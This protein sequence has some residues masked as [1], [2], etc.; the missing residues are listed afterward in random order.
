MTH[1]NFQSSNKIQRKRNMKPPWKRCQLLL[2]MSHILA[3][4]PTDKL[5]QRHFAASQRISP[6]INNNET[7]FDNSMYDSNKN[8]LS[9][10][11]NDK[12][13]L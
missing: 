10:Q 5:I 2:E 11:D 7:P 9:S 13:K 1:Q 12:T 8:D 3:S 4:P 6:L